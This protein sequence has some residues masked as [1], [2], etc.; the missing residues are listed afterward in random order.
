MGPAWLLLECRGQHHT[1]SVAASPG[2]VSKAASGR[3]GGSWDAG[4]RGVLF[5]QVEKGPDI[6]IFW[7]P[8]GEPGWRGRP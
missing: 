2:V 4:A 5:N 6:G 8:P 1:S 7:S 3:E